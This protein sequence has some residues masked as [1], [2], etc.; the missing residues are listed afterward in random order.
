[1]HGSSARVSC[2]E[3]SSGPDPVSS[4]CTDSESVTL[5]GPAPAAKPTA[6]EPPAATAVTVPAAATPEL[7]C[8]LPVRSPAWVGL[9]VYAREATVSSP[10]A[11]AGAAYP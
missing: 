11:R 2:T 6:T 1:W 9:H 4:Q 10:A 5:A 8:Q 3:A 7:T